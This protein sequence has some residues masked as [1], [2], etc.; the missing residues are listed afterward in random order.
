M[1]LE[2]Y[3]DFP[4]TTLRLEICPL[5]S[6]ALPVALPILGLGK[7]LLAVIFVLSDT[8]V[9]NTPSTNTLNV[10]DVRVTAI[11]CHLLSLTDVVL[12]KLMFWAAVLSKT[13]IDPRVPELS[14]DIC[15][16]PAALLPPW[17]I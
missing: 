2:E 16:F 11:W 7:P 15:K 6:P 8:E 14:T 10:W 17:V 9:S 4:L 5:K 13:W 12:L 1:K 3:K